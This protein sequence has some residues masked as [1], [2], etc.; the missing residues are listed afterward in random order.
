MFF[1][2]LGY[3]PNQRFNA[4]QG[5][6]RLIFDDIAHQRRVDFLDVFHMCHTLHIGKRLSLDD[7]T[8]PITDLLLTKLQ[9][10]E[11]NK[12]DV[13]DVIAILPIMRLLPRPFRVIERRSTP[14]ASQA[15][16]P[17]TGDYAIQ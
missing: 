16:A 5:E 3:E 15:Y 17:M 2:D 12:K 8:I 6:T 7:Y 11:I 9:I 10:V 14:I 1:E 4:L 13:Q